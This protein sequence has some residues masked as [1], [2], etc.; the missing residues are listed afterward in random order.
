MQRN[1]QTARILEVF[2]KR[3]KSSKLEIQK[4]FFRGLLSGVNF[5]KAS[6]NN[7]MFFPFLF[8]KK[9]FMQAG[10]SIPILTCI[11]FR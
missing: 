4:S 6:K 10:A 11:E 7:S 2:S 8:V 5:L 1:I 9:A 3:L